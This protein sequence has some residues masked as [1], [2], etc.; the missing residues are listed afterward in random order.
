[1]LQT[2][3]IQKSSPSDNTGQNRCEEP[4]A[5]NSTERCS[6]IMI[7]KFGSAFFHNTETYVRAFLLIPAS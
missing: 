6:Q 7:T 4:F 5:Q 2:F 1:M 3:S